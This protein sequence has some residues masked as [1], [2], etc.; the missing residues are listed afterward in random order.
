[1]TD[2]THTPDHSDL[3]SDVP[4]P[5]SSASTVTVEE[6]T[7]ESDDFRS[8]HGVVGSRSSCATILANHI[9]TIESIV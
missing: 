8:T 1:M 3:P 4:A 9:S 6:V 7:S 2:T 5:S